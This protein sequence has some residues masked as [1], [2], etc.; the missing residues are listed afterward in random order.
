MRTK[1]ALPVALLAVVA[2]AALAQAPPPITV[3]VYPKVT[4]N[5]AGTPAHPQGVRLDVRIKVGVPEGYDPPLLS[6]IDV[7]FPRGS[8]Y[9]GGR[10]PTCS[11]RTLERD[12]PA[13]CR[14]ASIMGYGGGIARAD[15]TFSY[16]KIT[17]VN[18]GQGLVYFYTVLNNPARVQEPVP[19]VVTKLSGRWSYKLHVVIPKNLQVVAGIPLVLQSLHIAAGR[20]DWLATTYCPPDHKWRWKALAVFDDGQQ[21]APNGVVG[22]RP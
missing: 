9:N 8:R 5:R 1:L 7:W 21:L 15:T 22:C 16:P 19:G 18:G 3:R 10:Y 12:G 6:E 2:A 14:T 20:G 17:V 13:G 4:P 11:A